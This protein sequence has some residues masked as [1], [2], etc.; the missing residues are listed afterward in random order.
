MMI[1]RNL[2]LSLLATATSVSAFT[3]PKFDGRHKSF[4]QMTTD[5]G[6]ADSSTENRRSF[7]TKV[8]I[9]SMEHSSGYFSGWAQPYPSLAHH[10]RHRRRHLPRLLPYRLPQNRH[11]PLNQKF[12][13]KSNSHLMTLCMILTLKGTS[14]TRTL[15][16]MV[17]TDLTFVAWQQRSWVFG[18]RKRSVRRNQ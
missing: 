2:I 16:Y 13:S 8:G 4:L 9:R 14:F 6:K 12:G 15:F 10:R 17:V 18:W 5:N 1:A 7:V 3:M 11:R